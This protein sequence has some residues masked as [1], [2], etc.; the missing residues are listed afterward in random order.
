MLINRFFM[1]FVV[2]LYKTNYG[3]GYTQYINLTSKIKKEL[4]FKIRKNTTNT[5]NLEAYARHRD[6]LHQI[7]NNV[8]SVPWDRTLNI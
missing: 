4:G 5:C 3:S 8:V 7:L 1:L 6:F 2:Y